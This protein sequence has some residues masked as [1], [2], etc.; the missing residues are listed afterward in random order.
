MEVSEEDDGEFWDV[1]TAN[2]KQVSSI[3]DLPELP[4]FLYKKA[5]NAHSITGTRAA[6]MMMV[7]GVQDFMH[8]S[9]MIIKIMWK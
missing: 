2:K 7:V 4:K 3:T 9:E 6:M 1:A 5:I 8:L